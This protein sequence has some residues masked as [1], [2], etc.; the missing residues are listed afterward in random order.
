MRE[1]GFYWVKMRAKFLEPAVLVGEWSE[2]LGSWVLPNYACE[3]M[4]D[5][6]EV[7][8]ERLVPPTA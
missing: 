5:E 6:V 2:E 8:S 1:P 4:D 7:L 3:Y